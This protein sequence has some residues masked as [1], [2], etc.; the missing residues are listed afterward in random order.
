MDFKESAEQEILFGFV[1]HRLEMEERL[2]LNIFPFNV[3]FAQHGTKDGK[4]VYGSA[5]YEP[6]IQSYRS[7]G[8][9]RSMRYLNGYG[10]NSMLIISYDTK[11]AEYHG[12]K[13]VNGKSVGM[14]Y[15]GNN[16]NLFFAHFTA[17]GLANGERC[18]FEIKDND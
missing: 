18:K 2:E 1:P 15:G 7:E 11:K 5:V 3:L 8:E 16:W 14:A 6:D 17:L 4:R 9:L 12:E 10:G 13:F